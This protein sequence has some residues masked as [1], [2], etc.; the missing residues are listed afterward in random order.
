MKKKYQT[1]LDRHWNVIK[2]ADGD[3]SIIRVELIDLIDEIDAV[4]G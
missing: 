4:K 3:L 2:H 1:I